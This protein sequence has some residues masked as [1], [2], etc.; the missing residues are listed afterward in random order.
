MWL[1]GTEPELS[2]VD[3]KIKYFNKPSNEEVNELY[4]KATV[5]VQTSRH[6]GFCLPILEAMAT[7]CPIICTD[8]HGNRDFSFNNKNCLMVE[9]DDVEG[10]AK[11]IN[12]LMNDDKL[13]KKLS[14]GA[15]K[16]AQNFKWPVIIDR[17]EKFYKEI[18][19][20]NP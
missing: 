5:F 6:E 15:L 1:F 10:L 3:S 9:H 16:T 8:A 20:Q 17:V 19:E 7:G 18:A 12:R 14:E 4:N 11:A 2:K 13:Q